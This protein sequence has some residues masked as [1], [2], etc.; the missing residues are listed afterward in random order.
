MSDR[1]LSTVGPGH[2]GRRRH[3]RGEGGS[4]LPW[5][6]LRLFAGVTHNLLVLGRPYRESGSALIGI[7]RPEHGVSQPPPE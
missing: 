4:V 3:N 1:H 7:S 2:E 5:G 6:S